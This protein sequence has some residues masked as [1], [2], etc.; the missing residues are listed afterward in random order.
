LRP[1]YYDVYAC[2]NGHSSAQV[3]W[4]EAQAAA[5]VIHR[6]TDPIA[7]RTYTGPDAASLYAERDR[8]RHKSDEIMEAY[9]ADLLPMA[10]YLKLLNANKDKLVALDTQIAEMALD[11]HLSKL[12][13]MENVAAHWDGKMTSREKA[14]VARSF[15]DKIELLPRTVAEQRQGR[16]GA[17]RFWIAGVPSPIERVATTA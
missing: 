11:K 5:M 7:K 12:L 13:G 10:E 17:A 16:V 3:K 4:L 15:F 8:L 6:L 1:E 2:R 14:N 9:N